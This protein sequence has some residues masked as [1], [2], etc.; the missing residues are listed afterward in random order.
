[1]MKTVQISILARVY[2][3]V[4][5]DETIGNRTTL[6]K[7]YS[8][9]GETLPFISSRAIKYAIREAL[10]KEGFKIDPFVIEKEKAKDSGN[11]IEY[12]DNDLFGFM[13]PIKN[14]GSR[15]RQAPI[16]ISYFKALKDT[17]VTTEFGARF[18]RDP[19]QS[20]NPAPFEIEVAD[21]IGRL[22]ILI[23]D[24]I[25]KFR[26]EELD[27][28]AKKSEL[29]KKEGEYYVLKDEERKNRLKKFLEILLTPKYVLPRRTNS[30]VI[31]EYKVGIVVLN[32]NG[33]LP[34][35]QYLDYKE[36]GKIDKDKIEKLINI[37]KEAN[38]KLY[39]IDYENWTSEIDCNLKD[40]QG[41]NICEKINIKDLKD[42]IDKIT[43]HLI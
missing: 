20:S 31:P 35:Y 40:S 30:L 2:G 25:G 7:F 32:N 16:A 11:P 39:I 3:N 38:S 36:P 28:E 14:G 29:L 23:Y 19:L 1:M 12:I 22:N 37:C 15:S 4:N 18:P 26:E 27:D 41:N 42:L 43:E 13:V 34:I 17:P 9:E 33:T 5:A 10:S 24:Y 8:S 21:F 6:K